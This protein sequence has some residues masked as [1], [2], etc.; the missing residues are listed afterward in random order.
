MQEIWALGRTLVPEYLGAPA[1]AAGAG[2]GGSDLVWTFTSRGGPRGIYVLYTPS[3]EHPRCKMTVNGTAVL[4]R[5][6]SDPGRG[7][8]LWRYQTTVELA[9]GVNRIALGSDSELPQ[10]EAIAVAAPPQAP[11]ASVD[12]AFVADKSDRARAQPRRPLVIRPNALSGLLDVARKVGR[13][14]A[15]RVQLAG[16]V[17][18]MIGA[19]RRDS[20]V[21]SA[22]IAWGGGPLNGQEYR[23]R[24][25]DRLMGLGVDV[26]VE[27]GAYIGTSTAFFARQ[28]VPVFSCE[29]DEKSFAKAAA[30][31]AE[32]P[33]VT[34]HLEDSRAFLRGLAADPALRFQRPLFY[35]DAHWEE[36]LPLADEIRIISERWSSFVVMVDDFQ[37]PGTSYA[38]DRYPNGL[39]LTL[40]YLQREGVR[41]Q[42]FAI[43]F[44]SVG[45]EGETGAKRGTLVLAPEKLYEQELRSDRIMFRHLPTTPG[46]GP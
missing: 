22:R 17:E 35:L 1:D 14:R 43:L 12:E 8:A 40:D 2:S 21:G 20:E 44:P 33:N 25:F 38:Y 24:M 18:T 7:G 9:A 23:Q 5:A 6:L 36:D 41:L 15:A 29:L 4:H 3:D 42:D 27:T 28:G 10:I 46:T 45:P 16:V 26:V 13:D 19:A 37:V 39:E 31:L 11:Y 32:L 34:L 30:H